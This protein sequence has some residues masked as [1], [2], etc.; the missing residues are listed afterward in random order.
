LQHN[1][2]HKH[3]LILRYSKT[4]Q[5]NQGKIIPISDE[6]YEMISTGRWQFFMIVA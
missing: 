1:G 4:D 2:N 3:A 6:L 5:Y